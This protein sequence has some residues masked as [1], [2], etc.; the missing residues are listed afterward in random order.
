VLEYAVFAPRSRRLTFIHR[1]IGAGWDIATAGKQY[2]G[3]KSDNGA[4]GGA[5]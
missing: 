5:P 3:G 1:L 4:R 2:D